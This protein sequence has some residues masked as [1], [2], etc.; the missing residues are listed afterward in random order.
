V[1]ERVVIHA[2][3]NLPLVVH[4]DQYA[5]LA[6]DFA[7]HR[8]QNTHQGGYDENGDEEFN[9]SESFLASKPRAKYVAFGTDISPPL[10]TLSQILNHDTTGRYM[11]Q[12]ETPVPAV[13][14][15]L[16]AVSHYWA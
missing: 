4:P 13:S 7:Q 11:L 5:S 9:E 15:R 3:H 12:P 16:T 6:S 10:R 2:A 14:G 8:Q 1:V